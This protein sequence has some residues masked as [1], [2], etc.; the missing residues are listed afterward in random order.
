MGMTTVR[1]SDVRD[2]LIFLTQ[3][4]AVHENGRPKGRAYLDLIRQQFPKEEFQKTGS[5]IRL[6][7]SARYQVSG[8][9]C[10][11]SVTRF[12][13]ITGECSPTV[14]RLTWLRPCGFMILTPDT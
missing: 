12:G 14:L 10:Q 13:A 6:A 3:L 2:A 8:A 11:E 4:C 1:D 7:L 5:N 9:R